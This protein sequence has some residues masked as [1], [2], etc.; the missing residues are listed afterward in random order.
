MDPNIVKFLEEDEDETMHSGADVD[1][2]TAELNRDIERNDSTQQQPSD[3]DNALSQGNSQ[4]A[5]QFLPQWQSLSHD[6]TVNF[7]SGQDLMVTEEK[8][9]HLSQLEPHQHG[10]DSENRKENDS[11]SHEFNPLPDN[12][13]SDAGA[14][15]QDDR[16]TFPVSQPIGSL[17][18]GEQSI[19]IQEPVREPNPDSQMHTLQNISSRPSVAMGSNDQLPMSME[20]NDQ[21]SMSTGKANQ[22]TT[23]MGI[24]NEQQ[25]MSTVNQHTTGMSSHQ[26]SASGMSNQQPMTSSNQQ[27]GT[28]LKLNKQVP[29]G[30]LLPIIQPQLDKDRAMQLHTLYFK[31][32]KNEISK[33]GFVRHM[34][35][36]VGDQM[37]KMAVYK[38]QT[39]AARNSQTA[40]NQFQSQPQASARQMQVPSAQM[41][42]DLSNSTGDTNTAKPREVESQADSQGVQVSQMSTSSSG[43]LSQERKHPA[44]PTQGLNKQQHMH[45]SQTSFPTYGSAGSSYSPFSATNAAS[46]TS[47]RPQPH[48]S[49]MKQAPPHQNMTVSHVGPSTQAMNMM[50]MPKF[51]RPHSFG[52]PK[53]MQGGSLT[54]VNS[55]TALQQNQVQWPSSTSKEPKIGVS[56][57]MTH[58]KQEPLDQEQ[59]HK[60]LSSLS[61]TPAKQGPASG[62]LKDESF[63]IQSSR[64]GFTPPTSLVPSNSVSSSI[65]SAM[66]T[67]ILSNSRM[68]SLTSP[69]G[70]GNN[71]KAPLK[72]P[73]VGQKKPMEAPGSSPPSSK[74]QKVSGAFLDQSIEQL[75]DVT[76][77][78]GVNLREEE[79]QLFSGSKEDSRVSE[80][81][82]RVV[83]EEEERLIL[84]K[85]PLQ[86]KVVEIMAK[87]GL[88][89][90][91]NDVERCL[92]L[93]V[94]ERM[95]G[96]ISNLIRLSKQRVDIEKPRHRTIITSDVRQQIM[97][98][99]RKAREEWEKKQAETEKSQKLNDPESTTGV[100]GDKEKDESRAK[101]TKA[102]KEEDDK[103]RTTAANVAVRA[104]TGVGDMLSRWQLM[105]EAK[106]KQGGSDTASGSQ[107]GKDVAR[108]P[109]ATSSKNTRENQEA[110]K[111]DTSAAFAT[112]ASVRKV[113]RNQVVIPRV[114]RSISVKDVIS[115]LERE[116]HMSKSTLLYRLYNKD[117]ADAV[118][119]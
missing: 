66:E 74:K 52:D 61:S 11:L 14:Q 78:S 30:M 20:P 36:I 1:A 49:Q 47:L 86:K 62:N 60:G 34:R 54:H 115:I 39:Q 99:N 41:P 97:T 18:S 95:R 44:F 63:E 23:S 71:S 21:Q 28:A 94:E 102:N 80:A 67:N 15:P 84:Q 31:L 16:N 112:P 40:P 85:I 10:L 42:I 22:P 103:M 118:A 106:Q 116:P 6:G 46:S 100:D 25:V 109:S 88:K 8:E 81:S 76:A 19:H 87:C 9:Q 56:S 65:P 113:G 48:D 70:T 17:T 108:K 12:P 93:C 64:T 53:K 69:I 5:S 7:G 45:F 75:N 50:N 73:L 32:K 91:S 101:S 98:I 104:A 33:D 24:S 105:I 83:Q 59:Q 90:M 110:E 114:T 82:R 55:N 29:F 51:D 79:E 89:N 43:V 27:P 92:S 37:L 68:P 38:L 72:K 26:A 3:S 58:V 107:A 2:F 13:L 111:R 4:T 35:S 96:L 77:V 119:E 57:S 117:N